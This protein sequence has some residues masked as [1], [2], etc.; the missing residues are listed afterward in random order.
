MEK[1]NDS[2]DEYHLSSTYMEQTVDS[3]SN[4]IPAHFAVCFE[5]SVSAN[6][7][8]FIMRAN[9]EDSSFQRICI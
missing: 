4:A 3:T 8:K 2:D 5:K 7:Y 6:E 9:V 1:E